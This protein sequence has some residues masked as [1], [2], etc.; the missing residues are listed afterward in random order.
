M[1]NSYNLLCS[2]V[3][4]WLE[5]IS[6]TY[7]WQ[8]HSTLYPVDTHVTKITNTVLL[9]ITAYTLMVKKFSKN[10]RLSRKYP[11]SSTILLEQSTLNTQTHMH[12]HTQTHM[13]NWLYTS[14]MTT[15]TTEV[16]SEWSCYLV[17]VTPSKV[18]LHTYIHKLSVCTSSSRCLHLL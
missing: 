6:T 7:L 11:A 3:L 17:T 4:E 16:F 13:A 9:T 18:Q 2:C 12:I 10:D 1:S 14:Y 5:G 8:K 15:S